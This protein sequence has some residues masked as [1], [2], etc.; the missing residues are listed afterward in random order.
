MDVLPIGDG[1]FFRPNDDVET[2]RHVVLLGSKGFAN[3]TFPL[4]PFDRVSGSLW[5]RHA[6]FWHRVGRRRHNENDQR[7][8]GGNGAVADGAGEIVAP[9]DPPL[10]GIAQRSTRRSTR[11]SWG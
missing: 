7:A 4:I 1:I 5:N 2:S 10:L 11:R 8:V 9:H 3:E 6:H